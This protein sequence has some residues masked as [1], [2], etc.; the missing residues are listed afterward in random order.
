[1]EDI[2]WTYQD[3]LLAI[4]G[5]DR[6]GVQLA[7][8]ELLRWFDDPAVAGYS[9]A[10]DY[11]SARE[12]AVQAVKQLSAAAHAVGTGADLRSLHKPRKQVKEACDA[13]H[14]EHR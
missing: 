3:V 5:N 13:C 8:D 2:S 4:E 12:A 1:M 11:G 9:S 14:R 7:A 10:S 6:E